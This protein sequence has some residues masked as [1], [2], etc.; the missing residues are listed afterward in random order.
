[1][2]VLVTGG[3]GF[4][5]VPLCRALGGAGHT[6]TVVSRDPEH[7]GGSAVGWEA[8]DAAVRE[9]DAVINLA[10]AP[11]AAGRWTAARKDQIVGS[12]VEATQAIVR[13]AA[14]ADR[15]P[16]VLVNVSAVGY[17]G[18]HGDEPLDET[19]PPGAGFLAD[20]CRAW[21]AEAARAEPLGLRVVRLRI[22][23]V[24]AP[25]GGALA[26]MLPPFRAFVGGPLGT[27]E[28]WM[29]WIHRDD[30][31]GLVVA[32][33]AADGWT[34]AVNATAP[35]PVTNRDFARALGQAL[36]RPSWLRTPGGALRLALG[37]MAEMLLTGQRVLPRVAERLGYRFRYRELGAALRA[38]VRR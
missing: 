37:E 14:A 34:G 12:R 20:V 25:D 18:P 6:V 36:A 24:L 10:G 22:G 2:R 3:T 15:R 16:A 13:A 4:L 21:E 19:A 8:I 1:M 11:I 35:E 32:A 17:Y 33:L 30:V 5:G 28:Q 9:A 26:R 38:S 29:S 27:G 7:A 23:I 31:T